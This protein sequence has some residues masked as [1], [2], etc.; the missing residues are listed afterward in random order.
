L[1]K[2]K[3]LEINA[4]VRDIATTN[5]LTCSPA[6]LLVDAA[7]LMTE[8][9]YSSIFVKQDNEIVGI[10]TERDALHFDSRSSTHALT[11]ISEVMSSPV[12]TVN[13]DMY[14]TDIDDQFKADGVRH[15]LV[16]EDSG[17]YIGIISKTDIVQSYDL[18]F[19]LVLRQVSS[20]LRDTLPSI[21]SQ[22]RV[23]QAAR[24]MRNLLVDAV[25]VS[26]PNSDKVGIFTERDLVKVLSSKQEDPLIGDYATEHII[27][28]KQNESLYHAKSMM[29]E[30]GCRHMGV[31]TSKGKL[32]GII[33]LS[34]ILIGIRQ[35]F[36]T[37][38]QAALSD[39][40]SQLKQSRAELYLAKQ[41]IDTSSEGV[42]ITDA[43]GIVQSCNTGFTDITGYSEEEMLGQNPSKISSGRHGNQFYRKMWDKISQEG[44]WKGEIYNRRKNGEVYPELLTVT[45]IYEEDGKTVKNYA[46]I[47]SDISKLKKDAD[48]IRTLAYYDAITGLP[49]RTLLYDRLDHALSRAV[50]TEEISALLFLDLDHFK[51]VNDSLGHAAGDIL[52]KKVAENIGSALRNRDTL[53]RIGGDE[54]VVILEDIGGD[55]LSATVEALHLAERIQQHLNVVYSLEGTEVSISSSIGITLFP[56]NDN[57]ANG[58]LKQ[59]DVA[60]YKAKETGRNQVHFYH[61]S[62]QE[63]ADERL[64]IENSLRTALDKKLFLLHYQP[65]INLSGDI[66][67]AEALIRW[68]HPDVGP[69]SPDKF[70]PIAEECGLI[71]PI[72]DWVLEQAFTDLRAWK[73]K[74]CH[75]EHLAV[76]I[77]P[78]QFYQAEFVSKIVTLANEHDINPEWIMLEITEGLVIDNVDRAIEI[79]NELKSEGF[80]FSVDDFG[81]GYSSL[82]YLKRLPLEQLKIDKSFVEDITLDPDNAVIVATIIA[83]G[84][85]LNLD[86]I[87]EGVE[88]EAELDFLKEKGCTNYQGYYFSRPMAQDQFLNY[89]LSHK[90]AED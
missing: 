23:S 79:I 74:D 71:I 2:P 40:D 61:T 9:R 33:N 21:S 27:S 87:A 81:T 11:S 6:T 50:R 77:S 19:Y 22:D 43:N 73:D 55:V 25:A 85:N 58:L 80:Q 10:W 90:I 5:L 32:V 68:T 63:K 26:Y 1:S 56:E 42:L 30:H 7:K 36:I 8:N 14:I 20:V 52:L 89:C 17:E 64:F 69:M 82:S 67:G 18:E 70:I 45:T 53:A 28:V 29:L 16:V 44:H 57:D 88:L 41:V 13:A 46:A 31:T 72:G 24:L 12:L 51:H 3:L 65:Q 48:E 54:F 78:R 66:I 86:V 47:F 37:E 35:G 76:N 49:N 75:L 4:V 60:M 34:D 83:M 15:Y 38:L 84:L 39:R 62:M 59:A